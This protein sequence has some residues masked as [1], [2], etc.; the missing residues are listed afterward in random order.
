MYNNSVLLP[1]QNFRLMHSITELQ[2]KIEKG[3]AELSFN[4]S[5]AELYEPIRYMLSLGGKRM[6]PML[7]MMGCDMFDGAVEKVVPAALGIELFHNFTLLHDDIMDK[8][9][10]RR[11]K[12]TVHEKWNVNTAILS[13]DAMFVKS[14]Q[15][16]MMTE[17]SIVKNI[18]DI[19]SRTAIEV[20]EGQQLD[21]DF[22][23]KE[24]VELDEYITMIELKTSVDRKSV[25]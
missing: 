12:Q 2:T 8:A 24:K 20:C 21:M 1:T 5:P 13:G 11:S 9:P 6:R 7:V 15:L 25:V 22:E 4:S 10:L 19:F 23:N 18:V 17:D 16:L 14:F 3:L